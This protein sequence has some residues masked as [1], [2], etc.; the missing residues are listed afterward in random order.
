MC[1]EAARRAALHLIRQDFSQLKIVL[2]FPEGAPNLG[3]QESIRITDGAAIVRVAAAGARAT[4]DAAPGARA[5]P[6]PTDASAVEAGWLAAELVQRRWSWPGAAGPAGP[7]GKARGAKPV[8]N[9]RSEGRRFGNSAPGKAPAGGRCLIPLDE[10]YEFTDGDVV[11]APSPSH[12][13]SGERAPPSLLKGEGKRKS[14]WLFT[15]AG[16]NDFGR[17]H[18]GDPDAGPGL[19]CVAGL[20]R[21]DPN[22]GEAWTMLTCEPGPDIA[23]YHNRQIVLMPRARW[24]DWLA[25]DVPAADLIAPTPAGTLVATRVR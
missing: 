23:P 14:K 19:F 17:V 5:V 10:F 3:R 7:G 11:T 8:Y 15:L 18:D 12:S 4:A 1:N 9:F 21:D 6:D 13:P 25:G 2:R 24:A 20:W 16:D 22:V